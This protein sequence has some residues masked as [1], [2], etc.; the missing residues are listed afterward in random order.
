[1]RRGFGSKWPVECLVS[2]PGIAIV[3]Q[4]EVRKKATDKLLAKVI[5]D[6]RKYPNVVDD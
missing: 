1:V 3:K 2:H 6:K 4:K 5:F